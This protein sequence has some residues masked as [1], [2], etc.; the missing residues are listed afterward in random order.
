MQAWCLTVSM[1]VFQT[2]GVGSNPTACSIRIQMH[3]KRKKSKRNV[4]CT[5]CTQLRWLGNNRG[6][7]RISDQKQFDKTKEQLLEV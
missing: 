4:R 2:L 6:K 7:K 3:Y 1:G 5:M